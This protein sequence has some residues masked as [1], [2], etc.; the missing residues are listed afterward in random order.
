MARGR[1]KI[2]TIGSLSGVEIRCGDCGRTK[3]WSREHI[4]SRALPGD[5][6]LE[7]LGR[8]LMCS[9]CRDQGGRGYNVELRAK[10]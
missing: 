10:A 5:A 8:S 4:A 7:D 1:K 6:T 2:R 3:L 9:E